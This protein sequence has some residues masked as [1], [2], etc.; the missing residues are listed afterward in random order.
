M[1]R[2]VVALLVAAAIALFF[3][4]DLGSYLTIDALKTQQDSFAAAYADNP[5]LIIAA[6]MAV[7]IAV[8]AAS[9]PGAAILTLAAG[10]LFGLVT[11]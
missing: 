8:T 10:A 2:A 7:Y 1:S 4:F 9:L 5:A 3:W 6:F 11:G